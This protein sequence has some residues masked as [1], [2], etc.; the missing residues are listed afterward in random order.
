MTPPPKGGS[1]LIQLG[2]LSAVI[3]LAAAAVYTSFLIIQR[4]KV[5][6][7]ASRYNVS[8]LISQ[9]GLEV[10]RLEIAASAAALP[11][12][13][14]DED[15]VGLRLDIVANRVGLLRSGEVAEFVASSP[16]WGATVTALGNAVKKASGLLAGPGGRER[17]RA[18]LTT[19]EP[20]NPLL[21]QLAAAANVRGGDL[22]ARDQRELSNLHW[23]LS[24]MLG[25]VMLGGFGLIGGLAWQNRLLTRAH[26]EVG[27]LVDNLRRSGDHLADA[28]ARVQQTMDEVQLQNRILQQRDHDL[29]VQNGRFDAALNNMSQALC[30]VNADQRLIVCNVRFL[31]LFGL[32]QG[33]VRPGVLISDIRR[34]AN[35]IGYYGMPMLEDVW[36]EQDRLIAQRRAETFFEEDAAGRAL[37]A[38]HQPMADGGWVATF[39]DVTERRRVEARISFMAHHDALTSLPNRLLFRDSLERALANCCDGGSGLSLLCLDLDHFKNVNDTLGHQAGDALLEAVARRLQN[40]VREGDVVARLGGDEFAILQH[41]ADPSCAESL[42]QRAVASLAQPYDIDGQR[43]V[44]GVSVGIATAT[45]PHDSAE[46]LLKSADMALYRAKA[47]GRGT[48]RFFENEMDAQM[49]A[50]RAI[51]LDLREA[52]GAGQLELHYQ[53]LLNMSAGRISGFEALLRWHHPQRGMISPAQFIPIA[54]ELGLIVPIGA[55]VVGRACTEAASW[56]EHLKVAVNLSPVQFR[57]TGL[58]DSV[59]RALR[60]SGLSPGRLELEITES[61]LLQNNDG[62]LSTLHELRGLGLRT[63][64]DDFGTGYS[65]LSY[66][67]SFPFDRIKIDQSFVREMERRPDCLAIVT[68]VAGLATKLGM[69]TTAEGVETQEQFDQLRDAGCTE[70][71]GYLI[72][73]PRS[74]SEIRRWFSA[75]HLLAA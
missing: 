46:I 74:A 20:L 55:W 58:V 36:A 18:V 61:A 63:A 52:L 26:V 54:E 38:S 66:L 27:A 62:V 57:G 8:W 19:F 50:R 29:Q 3:L 14:T 30:M 28:N 67:R 48:Y 75:E 23:L 1:R 17:F 68:S 51:E 35:A 72:D 32:S 16:E 37:A 71:Q 11:D 24:S 42:A 64:L 6:A 25:A 2:L 49:Q 9:A 43:A 10:G 12:S 31:E 7:E 65:S 53:P 47:D 45:S 41:G 22:V 13:D 60:E 5:L 44:V 69:T 59:R 70:A 33:M 21:A 4:Q 40:C 34:A 39:E 73:R 56:P 15:E